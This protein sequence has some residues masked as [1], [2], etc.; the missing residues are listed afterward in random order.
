MQYSIKVGKGLLNCICLS[1]NGKTKVSLCV[2]TEATL[3]GE[4]ERP[5]ASETVRGQSKVTPC[6]T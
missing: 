2:N 5:R 6:L 3:T 1:N 4:M